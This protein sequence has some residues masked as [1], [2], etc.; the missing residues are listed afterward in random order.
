LV[1]PSC[2]PVR[3]REPSVGVSRALHFGDV[4]FVR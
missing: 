1:R 3:V 2:V 4:T